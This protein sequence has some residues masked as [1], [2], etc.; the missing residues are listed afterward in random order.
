QEIARV[1]RTGGIAVFQLHGFRYYL[2]GCRRSVTRP[3]QLFYYMRPILS[4]I[5]YGLSG[6]QPRARWFRETALEP[7]GLERAAQAVHLDPV[8]RGGF[9][10]KPI[11]L[12][13]APTR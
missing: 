10:V 2:D 12:L 4:G 8:W 1:M 6:W 5:V 7:A 11:V 9:R 13:K 3:R